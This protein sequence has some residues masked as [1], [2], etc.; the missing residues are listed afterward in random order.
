MKAIYNGKL[1]SLVEME[2]VTITMEDE[3]G[4]RFDVPLENDII[5]DPTDDE[6]NNILPD[7]FDDLVKE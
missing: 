2:N 3:N 4:H 1:Y 7:Y 6:I 5:F